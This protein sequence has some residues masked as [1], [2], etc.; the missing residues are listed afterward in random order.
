[1][2]KLILKMSISLDGFVAGPNGEMDWVFKS[3]DKAVRQWEMETLWKAGV[4][5][6]GSRTFADMSAWWPTSTEVY[7][8]PMNAIPK[9]VF[10]RKGVD[11][12]ATTGSLKD[13]QAMRG[14][15]QVKTPVVGA[16]SWKSAYV[17]KG[18]LKTEVEALKAQDGGPILVHGGA[19]IAR[20]L[21]A[22][23][24]VDEY[25]LLVHPVA[26]GKGMA[27]FTDVGEPLRLAPGGM[28][29][30]PS[31]SAAKILRPAG[32]QDLDML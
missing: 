17:A 32:F 10:T 29:T 3:F 12:G 11:L 21:I 4:H 19:G 16:E 24:L 25:R 20:S 23:K 27:I 26:L 9:V 22:A 15:T 8:A 6:M 28:T 13:T 30:F 5:A 2:R 14:G 7:A 1:M 18:D 31:G